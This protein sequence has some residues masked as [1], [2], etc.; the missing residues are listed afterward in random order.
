MTTLVPSA[1]LDFTAVDFETAN[2]SRAS[3]CAVGA[4]RVRDGVIVDEFHTLVSPPDGYDEFEEGNVGV[5]GI[6]AEDVAG[7]PGWDI[8]YP[9]LMRFIDGDLL[10]GHNARFDVSVLL[11]A[12]G[13]C[14]LPWPELNTLCTLQLARA[15]LR[16]PSYSL[17]WVANHLRLGDFD[18][19]DPLADARMTARVLHAL[20]QLHRSSTVSALV[21]VLSVPLAPTFVDELD[22]V[23]SELD[24]SP[25]PLIATGFSD[26][27]VCFTGALRIMI[28]DEARRLVVE[29]G[30]LAQSGVNK[31]TTVLVTGDFDARTFRPGANFSAKLQKA[32]DLVDDG[33]ALEIITEEDFIARLSLS[34]E[35]L[36]NRISRAGMSRRKLPDWV[37]AQSGSGPGE[38]YWEW[39][40]A[41]LAH[42]SG[43]AVGGEACIWCE[44]PVGRSIH[45]VHRDRHVCGVHCNERLKRAAAR[46]WDR[47]GFRRPPMDAAWL[48]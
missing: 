9:Q 27:A 18:H 13:V 16:I 6:T 5:H 2:R 1:G 22:A 41:A 21:D 47:E 39:F 34:E 40:N 45:W 3:V 29:H 4:V 38:D 25:D 12:T 19:H 44:A 17:P 36:R 37:T 28:R 30:G 31:K 24:S 32:F 46:M 14:D 43:R 15:A 8:V 26:Q 11:N 48:Q 20:A 23:A 35:A 42:P 10:V 33:Q 7:A